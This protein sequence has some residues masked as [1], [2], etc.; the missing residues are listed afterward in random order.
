[1]LSEPAG[2]KRG[3]REREERL[4]DLLWA[5]KYA[6]WARSLLAGKWKIDHETV[7]QPPPTLTFQK[8]HTFH[9]MRMRVVHLNFEP[10]QG[11]PH[12]ELHLEHTRLIP[13]VSSSSNS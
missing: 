2:R 7:S 6:I 13:S 3:K 4:A 9:H 10:C 1:M 12:R 8:L 11:N 5:M